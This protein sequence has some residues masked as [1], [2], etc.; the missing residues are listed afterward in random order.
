MTAT[1]SRLPRA[2]QLLAGE[3]ALLDAVDD[4]PPQ[5]LEAVAEVAGEG[6][7]VAEAPLDLDEGAA[8]AEAPPDLDEGAAAVAEAPP[9]F[10][11]VHFAPIEAGVDDEVYA[12]GIQSAPTFAATLERL[13]ARGAG[14]D[15]EPSLSE[16]CL[17]LAHAGRLYILEAPVRRWLLVVAGDEAKTPPSLGRTLISACISVATRRACGWPARCG[18]PAP[19]ASSRRR[20]PHARR[21]C[22]RTARLRRRASRSSSMIDRS[23]RACPARC[24]RHRDGL[25]ADEPRQRR[26]HHARR[27]AER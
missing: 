13:S 10:G 25:R 15:S 18:W 24:V 5:P 17:F 4:A 22:R 20:S 7:A 21:A 14:A 27:L 3:E 12:A 26:H 19:R 11:G 1:L 23:C 16:S 2:Q 8:A 9:A 6:A